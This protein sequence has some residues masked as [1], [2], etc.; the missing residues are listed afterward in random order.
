[1][2]GI[3]TYIYHKNW[4]NVGKYTIPIDPMGKES[5]HQTNQLP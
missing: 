1:M 3:L 5:R 2:H 4:L